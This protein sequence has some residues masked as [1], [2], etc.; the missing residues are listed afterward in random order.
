MKNT[1]K[2]VVCVFIEHW[3]VLFVR[4]IRCYFGSYPNQFRPRCVVFKLVPGWMEQENRRGACASFVVFL[5]LFTKPG[6]VL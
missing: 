6:I 1:F 4:S 5:S 2:Q 3:N